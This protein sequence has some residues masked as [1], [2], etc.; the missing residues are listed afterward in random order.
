MI[1]K[2]K[3]CNQ[4]TL[5][6]LLLETELLKQRSSL[7]WCKEEEQSRAL[8]IQQIS[9]SSPT[10]SSSSHIHH[11]DLTDRAEHRGTTAKLRHWTLCHCLILGVCVCDALSLASSRAGSKGTRGITITTTS[12]PPPPPSP[13]SHFVVVNIVDETL[14]SSAQ[15][16]CNRSKWTSLTQSVSQSANYDY[17]CTHFHCAT[18]ILLGAVSILRTCFGIS[19]SNSSNSISPHSFT[20]SPPSLAASIKTP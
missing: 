17:H 3:K 8:S 9:Q 6:K 15:L 12:P 18:I 5:L 19:S 4:S 11:R 7:Q 13:V 14:L 2:G 16:V 10:N 20:V 1:E